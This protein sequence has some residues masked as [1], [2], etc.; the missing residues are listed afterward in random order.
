MDKQ[1]TT[2]LARHLSGFKKAIAIIVMEKI[3]PETT[4]SHRRQSDFLFRGRSYE[5]R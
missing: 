1:D 3:M 4:K 5:K 2:T